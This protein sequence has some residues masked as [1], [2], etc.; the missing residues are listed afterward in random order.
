MGSKKEKEAVDESAAERGLVSAED[1]RFVARKEFVCVST[2]VVVCVVGAVVDSVEMG[3]SSIAWW[4]GVSGCAWSLCAWLMFEVTDDVWFDALRNAQCYCCYDCC[5]EHCG[6]FIWEC[7]RGCWS[8]CRTAKDSDADAQQQQTEEK[9]VELRTVE[10]AN[11]EQKSEADAQQSAAKPM[12][13]RGS[14]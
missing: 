7:E 1:L 6:C 13:A 9:T 8:L 12:Y 3:M 4:F 5:L 2:F 14:L 10:R 11:I